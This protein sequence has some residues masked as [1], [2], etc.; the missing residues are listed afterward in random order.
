[1]KYSWIYD[2]SNNYGKLQLY[3]SLAVKQLGLANLF[4]S[5]IQCNLSKKTSAQPDLV[6]RDNNVYQVGSQHHNYTI[7]ICIQ[8]Q[9]LQL[10]LEI[11][12]F[13]GSKGEVPGIKIYRGNLYAHQGK[14]AERERGESSLGSSCNAKS[15]RFVNF[16]IYSAYG[17]LL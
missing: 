12:C 15:N 8:G 1:M 13:M 4:E 6:I 9:R 3:K 5:T 14:I 16:G 17:Q 10:Y 11:P 7:F 2:Y